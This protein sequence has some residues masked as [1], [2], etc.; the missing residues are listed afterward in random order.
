MPN[1][2]C[3]AKL[4]QYPLLKNGPELCGEAL[5][6]VIPTQLLHYPSAPTSPWHPEGAESV[7]P[8]LGAH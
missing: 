7:T 2:A 1:N 6:T 4:G 3:G 5:G 8:G